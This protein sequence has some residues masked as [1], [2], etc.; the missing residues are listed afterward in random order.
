V[1]LIAGDARRGQVKGTGPKYVGPIPAGSDGGRRSAGACHS[2]PQ[3]SAASPW[4]P[5]S[6]WHGRRCGLEHGAIFTPGDASCDAGQT[7]LVA[8]RARASHRRL[9]L[10]LKIAQSVSAVQ[11]AG[12]WRGHSRVSYVPLQGH[13]LA[14][15]E[16]VIDQELEKMRTS[17]SK[18][19][20]GARTQRESKPIWCAA[21]TPCR[22]GRPPAHLRCVRR[23]SAYLDRD[24]GRYEAATPV[25]LQ[26]WAVQTPAQPGPRDHRRRAEQQRA[27]MGRLVKPASGNDQPVAALLSWKNLR[28][29]RPRTPSSL[30]APGQR[31]KTPSRCRR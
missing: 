11:S 28:R 25:A 17:P 1:L 6:I 5:R 19:R 4:R 21:W 8:A 2:A 22:A 23:R 31:A 12:C 10:E 13:T 30:Q 16:T 29:A 24:I 26:K 9:V 15:L 14:E 18:P 7:C 3:P 20:A 27:I